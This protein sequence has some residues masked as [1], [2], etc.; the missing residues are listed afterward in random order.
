MSER[1]YFSQRNL[2][3]GAAFLILVLAYNF[4]PVT[5]MLE[6]VQATSSL[7]A[8][9]VALISGPTFGFLLSQLWW[10]YFQRRVELWNWEPVQLLITH[11][12]LTKEN[13]MKGKDKKAKRRVLMVYDYV[14]HAELHSKKEREYK[15]LSRYAYARYD[16]YVLLSTTMT[17]L[18]F[19][20]TLGFAVRVISECFI[21]GGTSFWSRPGIH[22]LTRLV[23]KEPW[24]WGILWIAT[25]VL[26]ISIQQGRKWVKYEYDEI[27]KAIIRKSKIKRDELK[28]VFPDYFTKT[29]MEKTQRN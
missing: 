11:Y 25:I 6:R 10:W 16:N 7:F 21:L 27:H 1:G 24:I 29:T 23:G 15:G 14:M 5:R 22:T 3:P 19:G 17:S 12:Q 26:L 8:A 28:K 9:G 18:I 13:P 20:A 4:A 2:I